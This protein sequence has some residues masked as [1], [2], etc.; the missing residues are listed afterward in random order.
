MLCN[1]EEKPLV[2]VYTAGHFA[3]GVDT[4]N[5]EL[6]K[7]YDS[8]NPLIGPSGEGYTPW[9]DN[10]RVSGAQFVITNVC[11]NPEAAFR[12]LDFWLT[13][14]A[15]FWNWIGDEGIRFVE[16]K[17]GQKN[18]FGEQALYYDR[19]WDPDFEDPYA[20]DELD[21][22]RLVQSPQMPFYFWDRAHAVYLDDIYNPHWWTYDLLRLSKM[23][24]KYAPFRSDKNLPVNI[25]ALWVDA[26]TATE[27]SQLRIAI[28]DY[29]NEH[30]IRFITGDLDINSDSQWDN[31]VN[32]LNNLQLD[33]FLSML[34]DAYDKTVF[35]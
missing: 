21:A 3:M 23:T 9:W 6:S 11:K 34:Q 8:L 30:M 2:G 19:R 17:E 7:Q 18:M 32:G 13:A 22:G 25:D 4:Q 27:I 14:E 16:A 15:F 29:I 12:Y 5:I 26:D 31:Y 20:D 28:T 24:E 33:K 10:T 1:N 35:G